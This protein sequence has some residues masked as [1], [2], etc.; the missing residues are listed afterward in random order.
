MG[1]CS[2]GDRA[3]TVADY[4][5]RQLP[6]VERRTVFDI[7]ERTLEEFGYTVEERNP[8]AGTL[9]TQ[10]V[11]LRDGEDRAKTSGRLSSAGRLRK[12]AEIRVANGA[13]GVTVYCHVS[14]QQQVTQAQRLFAQSY[15]ADTPKDTPIDRDAATT[16]AQNSVWQTIRRDRAAENAILTAIQ[17]G[18]GA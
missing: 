18:A 9:T 4:G 12:V 15:G 2:S 14:V 5:V 3:T 8:T 17:T 11:M 10:P 1:A 6:S 7:A 16:A 13:D